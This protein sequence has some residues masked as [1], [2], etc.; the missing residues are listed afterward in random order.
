[1]VGRR[2]RWQLPEMSALRKGRSSRRDEGGRSGWAWCVCV[3][4]GGQN[5]TSTQENTHTHTLVF[6]KKT[7]KTN[8]KVIVCS[9]ILESSMQMGKK[10]RSLSAHMPAFC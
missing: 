5:N 9:V 1:M 6:N 8:I 3:S 2:G 10:R 4:V 7:Q